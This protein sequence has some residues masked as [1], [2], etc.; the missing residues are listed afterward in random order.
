MANDFKPF[1]IAVGS[2][3]LDQATWETQDSLVYGFPTGIL[4]KERLNKAI[5]QPSVIAAAIAQYVANRTGASVLDNGDL[6]G[7]ITQMT[8][9][10]GAGGGGTG[11]AA[12]TISLAATGFAFV[13]QDAAATTTLSP[14]ITF[15][16]YL[17]NVTGTVTFTAQ[18]YDAT[19]TAL[20]SVT[21]GGT[22][23]NAT[24]TSAQFLARAGTRKVIV[25]ATITGAGAITLTDLFSVYR[26]D[27]GSDAFQGRLTNEAH[28]LG[29][30][31]DGTISSYTGA[32]GTFEAYKGLTRLTNVTVPSVAFSMVGYTGFTTT[33][34]AAQAGI[35]IDA[36]TGVYA[37]T[38]GMSAVN[39][40]V[41]FRAT[42]STGLTLDVVFSLSKSVQGAAGAA[43]T[44]PILMLTAPQEAFT[45]PSN[46]TTV[47]PASIIVTA[48]VANIPSPT[49]AW[50]IDGVTQ[51]GIVGPTFTF[52][53]F[54]AGAS[55]ALRC[56]A[57]GSDAST[58]FDV[59]TLYSL[60]NGDTEQREPDGRV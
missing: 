45:T 34:P 46:S 60:K 56:T 57:T 21:L 4:T 15:T 52:G 50:Q 31:S 44:A 42:L 24:M 30:L 59:L 48:T 22:S 5:R 20:G 17:Q 29:A 3:V 18:A 23:P 38:A 43:G 26:A 27:G 49:Y 35:T 37:V 11:A 53:S 39:A 2:R 40:T 58:A 13:F 47:S 14:T 55:H 6:A 25:T 8:T 7:L 16:A 12:Q 10:F 33:Y 32:G 19:G 51:A 9:A 36:T 28:T 1:A 54:A 41:T